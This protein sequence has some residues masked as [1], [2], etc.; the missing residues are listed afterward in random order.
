V[1]FLLAAVLV[2][3]GM[4][5]RYSASLKGQLAPQ[6]AGALAAAG[7]RVVVLGSIVPVFAIVVA[8][9]LPVAAAVALT[10]GGLA[11]LAAGWHTKFVIVR[12]AAYNQGFALPVLPVRGV[13]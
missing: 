3:L 5:W 2:R 1:A 7:T 4:W 10:I 6:A 13:R 8:L 11:A 12:R 9:A